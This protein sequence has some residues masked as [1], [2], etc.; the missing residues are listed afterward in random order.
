MLLAAHGVM[1]IFHFQNRKCRNNRNTNFWM[2]YVLEIK[3]PLQA[4]KLSGPSACQRGAAV[5]CFMEEGDLGAEGDSCSSTAVPVPP[6]CRA[7]WHSDR[8]DRAGAVSIPQPS[9][10]QT[11]LQWQGRD[12][13]KPGHQA[14]LEEVWYN[15]GCR[16]PCSAAQARTEFI[17]TGPQG[18][19]EGSKSFSYYVACLSQRCPAR[20]CQGRLGPN[21]QERE[22]TYRASQC[23]QS[24]GT[25]HL[26]VTQ[27]KTWV[28]STC[29]LS[30]TWK[31]S[32]ILAS[33]WSLPYQENAMSQII[34]WDPSVGRCWTLEHSTGAS[35]PP[36]DM[37][38]V[39]NILITS[40]SRYS[41][42][43]TTINKL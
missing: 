20:L 21:P 38:E 33:L 27:P 28:N 24:P 17:N 12:T 16:H 14:G 36:P 15:A 34:F 39:E 13:A 6:R 32:K 7:P 30:D 10:G 19:S 22:R 9:D 18:R 8:K 41:E 40:P 42:E 35:Q 31:L 37:T 1:L 26:W 25:A 29:K 3:N 2:P 5:G 23:S 11:A 4:L 43:I